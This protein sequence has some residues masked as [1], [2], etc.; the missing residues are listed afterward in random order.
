MSNISILHPLY[1]STTLIILYT[2][3][4]QSELDGTLHCD[5]TFYSSCWEVDT[6]GSVPCFIASTNVI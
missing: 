4:R 5:K 1:F 2:T 6:A 3:A